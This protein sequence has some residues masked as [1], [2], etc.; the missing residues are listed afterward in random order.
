M[1]FFHRNHIIL[2]VNVCFVSM[3]TNLGYR[4]SSNNSRRRLLC[5]PKSHYGSWFFAQKGGDYSREAIILNIAHWKS[6][7][8]YF[9]LVLQIWFLD[10]FSMSI[11]SALELESS[12]M[13]FAASDSTST[14]QGGNTRKRKWRKV[15][16]GDYPSRAITLNIS[17]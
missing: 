16:G 12:L 15:G 2:Y 11:S 1:I 13:S 9:A 5:F 7:P 14:W 10:C 8:K 17:V 3:T 6:C 4:I